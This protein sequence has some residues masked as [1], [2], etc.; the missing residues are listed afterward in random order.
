M[1]IGQQV[2]AEEAERRRADWKRYVELLTDKVPNEQQV[3]ELHDLMRR[4]GKTPADVQ[5]DESLLTSAE[6][7]RQRIAAAK[8]VITRE[9]EARDAV[10][11]FREETEMLTRQ[12][13]VR[14][15]EL[16]QELAARNKESAAAT[17]DVELLNRLITENPELLRRIKPATFAD[18][19]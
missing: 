14:Q 12:R 9:R 13:A 8:G 15:E 3:S 7:V 17:E 4:L 2:A 18:L 5:R 1:S 6:S 10:P 19:A 11:A 16:E